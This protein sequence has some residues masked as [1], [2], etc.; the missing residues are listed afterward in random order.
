M[1]KNPNPAKTDLILKKA[2]DSIEQGNIAPCYLI[3]GED[4]YAVEASLE[5]IV[6]KIL[7]DA[8][9]GLNLFTFEGDE[10]IEKLY[11]EILTP[12]LL[13]GI[14]VILLRNTGLFRSRVSASD[15][16]RK[17]VNAL[18]Q[19]PGRAL[20]YFQI[21]LKIAGLNTADLDSGN[22]KNIPEKDWR[23][24]LGEDYS[25]MIKFVPILAGLA[26]ENSF[27]SQG[28]EG[29]GE[30]ISELLEKGFPDGNILIVTAD[31]VDQRKNLYKHIAEHGIVITHVPPNMKREE[32]SLSL[33]LSG[34]IL[35]K[36]EKK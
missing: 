32:L 5:Q 30:E 6:N 19:D 10:N 25:E 31:S 11:E 8:L 13:S 21:F 3:Y 36:G 15:S 18:D 12:S 33:M 9:N 22:W 16:F 7:P 35:D 4:D 27:T 29:S 17:A 26:S 34:K 28:S 1:M 20:K 2:L 23:K 14:K 24:L